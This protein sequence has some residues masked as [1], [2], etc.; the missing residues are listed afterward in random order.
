MLGAVGKEREREGICR[1]RVDGRRARRE[2]G[3]EGRVR[4]VCGGG[5][6]E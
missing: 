3:S 4:C 5:G 1:G 2:C 6:E